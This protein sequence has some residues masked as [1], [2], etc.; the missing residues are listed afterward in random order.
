MSTRH[1]MLL[2]PAGEE[3][4]ARLCR[5]CVAYADV[6]ERRT[7]RRAAPLPGLVARL[8]LADALGGDLESLA[9]SLHGRLD[10]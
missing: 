4:V 7:G 10:P 5:L 3:L 9:A 2:I 1:Q 6:S 8:L